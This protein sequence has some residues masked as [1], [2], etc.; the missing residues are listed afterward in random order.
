MI[1]HV[2]NR[3]K[4]FYVTLTAR[5][6]AR[7]PRLDGALNTFNFDSGVLWILLMC[8]WEVVRDAFKVVCTCVALV[9]TMVLL[10]FLL[11]LFVVGPVFVIIA[12]VPGY[13]YQ[14]KILRKSAE[15]L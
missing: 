1:K 15:S 13:F 11:M 3:L 14:Q 7:L 8:A 6:F 9:V 5:T 4:V 12:A 2:W 10:A